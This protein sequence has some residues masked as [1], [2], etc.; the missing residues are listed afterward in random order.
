MTDGWSFDDP[1]N[2][3]VITLKRI[4]RERRHV[5]LVFHSEDD[6]SW[7]FLDGDAFELDDAMVVGLG[8]IVGHDPGPTDLSDLPVGWKAWRETPAEPWQ[9]SR[10]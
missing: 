9:R 1:R 5:L 2:V 6:G 3:A 10:A 8:T 4:L 7:Q